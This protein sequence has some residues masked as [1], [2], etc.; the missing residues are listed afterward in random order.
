MLPYK[1]DHATF[2]SDQNESEQVFTCFLISRIVKAFCPTIVGDLLYYKYFLKL[3]RVV[4]PCNE[5]TCLNQNTVWKN[6]W[7]LYW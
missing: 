5:L 3:I 1:W 6:C 7:G 4:T 2:N